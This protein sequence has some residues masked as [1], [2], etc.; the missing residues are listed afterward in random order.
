MDYFL[1]MLGV[2]I[3]TSIHCV[4]MCGSMVLTYAVKGEAKGPWYRRM[5]PHAA[6]QGAKLLS[7]M[8][9]GLA[10]GSIGSILNIGGIRGWVTVFAGAF[11][12]L[13]GLQMSGRFPAL[14]KLTFRPPKSLTDAISRTRKKANADAEEGRSS[15]ATPVTFGALTGLMPCGPLQAAQLAAAGA[16]SAAAGAVTMLGF[17]LGTAPLM[18][19]FGTVSGMLGAK[20]KQRMMVVA[21][22]IVAV[23]GLVML[24]RGL[25]LVGSPV[26][27]NS[28]KAAVVGGPEAV[29][30]DESQFATAEDGVVEVPLTISGTRFEPQVLAIPADKPVRLIVDRQEGNVCSDQLA[31]PQLGILQTLTPFGTTAV[32][33]PATAAGNYTMTC[34]MGMMSGQLQVGAGGPASTSSP[35]RPLLLGSAV[36]ALFAYLLKRTAQP[37]AEPCLPAS[38]KTGSAGKG[39]HKGAHKGARAPKPEPEAPTILGFSPQEVLVIASAVGAAVIAGLAFGGLFTY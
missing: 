31:I 8:M 25:M 34:Q 39:A 37:V 30:V 16:G 22:V 26:T 36:I 27:A 32:E 14:R 2:G 7:Y 9:V 15:L 18:L 29:E 10:L 4:A 21:A 11:M 35:L 23:L 5:I 12:I 1:P 20:F 24:N 6:Y 17:G 3:V 33:I 28:L 19:A 13:L 38:G